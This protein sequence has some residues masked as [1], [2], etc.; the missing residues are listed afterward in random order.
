MGYQEAIKVLEYQASKTLSYVASPSYDEMREILK[1]F[2]E[3]KLDEARGEVFGV[4]DI[5][6]LEPPK[7]TYY[8][9]V[10][11][12]LTTGGS[13]EKMVEVKRPTGE[14]EL[15]NLEHVKLIFPANKM[16]YKSSG[17]VVKNNG[18]DNIKQLYGQVLHKYRGLYLIGFVKGG[19]LW[20]DTWL[21]ENCTVI[22]PCGGA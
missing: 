6:C 3:D 19:Y 4:G 16:P 7:D 9:E 18:Q 21:K 14:T 8:G 13:H 2:A 17:P 11:G 22:W 20:H 1:A 10:V 12:S 15:W 5:V